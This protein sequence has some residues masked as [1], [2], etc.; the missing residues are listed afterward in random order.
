VL[1]QREIYLFNDSIEII[2]D[3]GY[4]LQGENQIF[5]HE[6]REWSNTMPKCKGMHKF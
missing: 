6:N 5:C 1:D 4:K 3:D 2:C